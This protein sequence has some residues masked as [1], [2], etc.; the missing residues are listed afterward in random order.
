M[1]LFAS[2]V[3]LSKACMQVLRCG[4]AAPAECPAAAAGILLPLGHVVTAARAAG[5]EALF[6]DMGHF[7]RVSLQ[8]STMAMVYPCILASYLGQGAPAHG[9]QPS[10]LRSPAR[11]L[12]LWE[13]HGSCSL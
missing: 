10:L 3:S 9:Q 11:S 7:N 12:P 5:A 8:V 13:V 1:R 2:I 4:I 6:A